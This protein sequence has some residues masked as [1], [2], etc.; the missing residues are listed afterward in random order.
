MLQGVRFLRD[1]G[2][3]LAAL[4]AKTL[5]L[6]DDGVVKIGTLPGAHAVGWWTDP[7][8]SVGVEDSCQIPNEDM[9]ADTLKLTALA[10]IVEHLMDHVAATM[11]KWNQHH[12]WGP[13]ISSFVQGLRMKP[14][15]ELLKVT[16]CAPSGHQLTFLNLAPGSIS[17]LAGDCGPGVAGN[18]R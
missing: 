15:D 8:R 11:K 4:S 13:E 9:H 5:M 17:R 14:L 3:A 16:S 1:Q 12:S 7:S 10:V 2:L 6:T 18:R